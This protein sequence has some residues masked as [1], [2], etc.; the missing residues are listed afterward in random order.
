MPKL[1]PLSYKT[2]ARIFEADG[3]GCVCE[4]GDHSSAPRGCRANATSSPNPTCVV[5]RLLQRGRVSFALVPN[6]VDCAWPQ[7]TG[8]STQEQF[9]RE[10]SRVSKLAAQCSLPS[11]KHRRSYPRPLWRHRSGFPP[12]KGE[13]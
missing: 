8:A 4:E 5:W 9:Q 3:F 2:L 13:N 12:R 1:S 11:R 10:F 6:V 7:L